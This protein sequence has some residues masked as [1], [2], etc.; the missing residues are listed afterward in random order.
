MPPK[1]RVSHFTTK[2]IAIP[3]YNST[4]VKDNW[5]GKSNVNRN[6]GIRKE[7]KVNKKTCKSQ[8]LVNNYKKE[9]EYSAK[10]VKKRSRIIEE[11]I[12]REAKKFREAVK[13]R[14]RV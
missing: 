13:E 10:P 6:E 4:T 7:E 1:Q 11:E 2:N 8:V 14:C 5:S 9:S 3:E 12:A